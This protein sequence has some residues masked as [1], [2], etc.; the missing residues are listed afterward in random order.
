M[1]NNPIF[2]AI[3]QISSELSQVEFL[4]SAQDTKPYG[5]DYTEDLFFQPTAVCF[6][7]ST[8]EVSEIMKRCYVLEVPVF[9]RGAGTGLSG[10]CL[11]VSS[12]LVLSTKKLNRIVNIDSQNL[13]ATVESGVINANLK[14]AVEEYGLYCP[15]AP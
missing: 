9:T 15:P 6:P 5:S 2:Q 8:N 4:F 3:Q 12:G 1:T 11:P 10:A 13:T 7:R 14:L